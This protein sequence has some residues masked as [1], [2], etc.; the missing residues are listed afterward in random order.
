MRHRKTTAPATA[1]MTSIA[2]PKPNRNRFH[3]FD[4]FFGGLEMNRGRLIAAPQWGHSVEL[5]PNAAAWL[6]LAKAKGGELGM[7][8]DVYYRAKRAAMPPIPKNGLRHSFC[9]YHL[10]KFKNIALTAHFAGNSPTMIDR[11]YKEL[12]RPKAATAFWEL[13]PDR[14]GRSPT[15]APKRTALTETRKPSCR[16]RC[17]ID[18]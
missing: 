4:S 17:C 18:L 14:R 5:Q 9:S 3:R 2:A 7:L 12:V 1:G 10:A 16:P 8:D 11:H 6:A 13:W 15:A